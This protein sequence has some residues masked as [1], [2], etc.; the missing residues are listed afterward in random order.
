MRNCV[1]AT[2]QETSQ[3]YA[4]PKKILRF[5]KVI[6][7]P[8]RQGYAPSTPWVFERACSDTT[9]PMNE[10]DETLKSGRGVAHQTPEKISPTPGAPADASAFFRRLA[11]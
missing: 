8:T 7:K 6:N 9:P 3:H 2:E 11:F 4:F 1:M 5:R 10:E